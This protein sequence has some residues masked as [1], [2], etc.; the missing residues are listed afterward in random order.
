[1]VMIG[2]NFENGHGFQLIITKYCWITAMV[3]VDENTKE[4]LLTSV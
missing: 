3:E 1:M 4:F 2:P